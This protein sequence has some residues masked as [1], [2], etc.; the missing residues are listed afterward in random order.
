MLN[1]ITCRSLIFLFRHFSLRQR[2]QSKVAG[3]LFR[4]LENLGQ[5]LASLMF[6]RTPRSCFA[7]VRVSQ[8][9]RAHRFS[10]M[11]FQWMRCLERIDRANFAREISRSFSRRL[12]WSFQHLS[13]HWRCNECGRQRVCNLI[14]INRVGLIE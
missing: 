4:S 6:A 12:D 1:Q 3:N 13:M 7:Q 11:Q 14:R 8:L 5:D 2:I 10:V 9:R